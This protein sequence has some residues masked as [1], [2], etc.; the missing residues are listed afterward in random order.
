[1]WNLEFLIDVDF[2]KMVYTFIEMWGI[3]T[4][5]FDLFEHLS[6]LI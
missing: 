2:P 3:L 1:M 4:I 6:E 5:Y